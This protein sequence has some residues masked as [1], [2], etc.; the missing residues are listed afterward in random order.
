MLLSA[1][2]LLQ[3]QLTHCLPGFLFSTAE[4]RLS[5]GGPSNLMFTVTSPEPLMIPG[6]WNYVSVVTGV[7]P[8]LKLVFVPFDLQL[9]LSVYFSSEFDYTLK[10]MAAY[11]CLCFSVWQTEFPFNCPL[12]KCCQSMKGTG[13][14]IGVTC[15]HKPL[16]SIICSDLLLS[17]L[18]GT[19]EE[20]CRLSFLLMLIVFLYLFV[21]LLIFSTKY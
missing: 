18:L 4:L 9:H 17:L 13:M 21:V 6:A 11:R 1:K 16:F 3:P 14:C 7:A 20:C 5:P 10:I 8:F 19:W 2:L 15:V 12:L